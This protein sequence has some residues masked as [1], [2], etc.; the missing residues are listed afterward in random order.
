MFHLSF[1]LG[2]QGWATASFG[3]GTGEPTDVRVSH[4]SDALGDFAR[5]VR[6]IL[7]GLTGT[8]FCFVEEP[9]SHV[10]ALTRD[11]DVVRV[12]VYRSPDTF[13][14]V[15]GEHLLAVT[16]SP[17]ELANTCIN[18]LRR[19]VD[20]HGEAEYRRRWNGTEFPVAE[21]RDLLDLRRGL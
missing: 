7:R 2:H 17:R 20:E 13:G 1:T 21:F 5:A 9:G 19:V 11:D 8:S 16:C 12:D 14:R 18:C 3:D 4:L 10:F 6:G 15:R